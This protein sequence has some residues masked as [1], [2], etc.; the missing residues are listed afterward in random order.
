MIP[1]LAGGMRFSN[2]L[3]RNEII[4]DY[5]VEIELAIGLLFNYE[6]IMQL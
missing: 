2:Y 1:R 4:F 3:K 5:V 6:Y